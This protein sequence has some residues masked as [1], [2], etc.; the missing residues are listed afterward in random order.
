[1]LMEDLKYK[2]GWKFDYVW[3]IIKIFEK[4]EYGVIYFRKLLDFCVFE[5]IYL[6]LE[7]LIINFEI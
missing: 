5:F 6:D 7:N 1:M 3:N 4:F 2:F